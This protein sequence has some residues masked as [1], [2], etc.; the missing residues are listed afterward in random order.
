MTHYRETADTTITQLQ[1]LAR[2]MQD[3]PSED[4]NMTASA[5]LIAT[6]EEDELRS[7]LTRTRTTKL[8]DL[9]ESRPS[10]GRGSRDKGPCRQRSERKPYYRHPTGQK[11]RSNPCDHVVCLG[12]PGKGVRQYP[13]LLKVEISI[14]ER[15]VGSP[16]T[17]FSQPTFR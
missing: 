10:T 16:I 8:T 9:R 3:K 14:P 7:S 17:V 13:L 1:Q 5:D 15:N 6:R 2:E 11:I 12:E 4:T